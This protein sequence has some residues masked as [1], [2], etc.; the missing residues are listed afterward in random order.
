MITADARRQNKTGRRT[1][2]RGLFP[3]TSRQ[4]RKF[5]FLHI[6]KT[7]GTSVVFLRNLCL[8]KGLKAPMMFGHRTTLRQI[9]KEYPRTKVGF[10]LRDP[11]ERVVSAFNH[12][13]R[14]PLDGKPWRVEDAVAFSFFPSACE[15]LLALV[16]DEPR[17]LGAA[18]FA[19]R[20]MP[21]I[22]RGYVHHFESAEYV[23]SQREHFYAVCELRDLDHR[24]ADF[25]EPAGVPRAF[26]QE[27]Y[28]RAREGGGGTD[29]ALQRLSAEQRARLRAHFAAE[30]RIY[31]ALV[32]LSSPA[33][34]DAKA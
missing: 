28:R 30:Y 22:Q 5:G 1:R 27:H 19:V 7:G 26:V 10:V 14:Q 18:E 4:N 15:F 12:R 16:S 11:L 33:A 32:S 2:M 17:L 6:G 9:R 31:E 34:G 3:L 13:L 29:Q 8:E 23:L 25:F 20:A 21:H 24:V